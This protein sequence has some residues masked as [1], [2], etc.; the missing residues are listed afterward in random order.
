MQTKIVQ[1]LLVIVFLP[2]TIKAQV[3]MSY[4]Y[5]ALQKTTITNISTSAFVPFETK[6]NR[7]L[8]N[9]IYWLKIVNDNQNRLIEISSARIR[10]VR[11]FINE[12]EVKQLPDFNM[13]TFELEANKVM[14]LRVLCEK[15]G[16]FP[17]VNHLKSDVIKSLKSQYI[18]YGL[19]Y[20]LAI[21]IVILNL[22]YFFNFKEITFLYYSF[23]LTGI[24]FTIL[25]RDGLVP[26]L[27]Q[28]QW[29]AK[30]GEVI[31]H[32]ATVTFGILFAS[33]YLRH[34]LYFPLLKYYSLFNSLMS[35][36]FFGLYVFTDTFIWFALAQLSGIL[37]LSVYWISSL[38]LFNKNK[39]SAFFAIAYSFILL[40]TI[41]FFILP[42]FG[43]PNLGITTAL[44]KVSSVFEMLILS[45]A[46]VYRMRILHKENA[47]IQA[48]LFQRTSQI[49]KLEDELNKLKLGENN[50]ITTANLSGREVEILKMI[51]NGTP[52]KE[53][54]DKL[55]ISVNTIKYHVKNLYD[56]L[57]I[58]SRQEAK[59]KAAALEGLD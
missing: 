27:F 46:V 2:L 28:N 13:V 40:L 48:S 59:I 23:F 47:D 4:Y 29:L 9:G 16:G 52:T 56:K 39:F 57:E 32:F 20:G 18:S 44:M 38:L 36:L 54:A 43:L 55:F 3:K 58:S 15:E 24:I 34:Q 42:I 22:F 49:E 6:I 21:V 1:I 33:E 25:F 5:D 12:K 45:Y 14:Y 30:D 50:K 35:A 19:Y 31:F 37:L 7:G 8:E 10:K 51:A 17:V 11:G 26:Y 41:D 53:M